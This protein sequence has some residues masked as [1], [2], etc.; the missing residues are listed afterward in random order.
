MTTITTMQIATALGG[1]RARRLSDGGFLVPCPVR[2]HGK[3]RGDGSPSLCLRDG[4]YR[5]LVH[6]FAGC[7]HRDAFD[8]LRHLGLLDDE[9]QDRR[10][11]VSKTPPVGDD[12]AR[13]QHEKARWLWSHRQPISG[14]SIGEVYLR[15]ARKTPCPLPL[16]PGFPPLL[17][18]NGRNYRSRRLLGDFKTRLLR[19]AISN[20]AAQQ[21][22]FPT[23]A[24]WN[25]RA[26]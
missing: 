3:E 22:L 24:K 16:T 12:L 11:V 15:E 26:A 9:G 6:Y 14:E 23:C 20:H 1:H 18:I 25:G 7:D 17:K 21:S 4:V 19:E 5:L 8:E 2:S 13:K 10:P